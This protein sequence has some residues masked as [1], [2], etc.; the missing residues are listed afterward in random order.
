MHIYQL[1]DVDFRSFGVP[2]ILCS[3]VEISCDIIVI[4][5]YL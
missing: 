2:Y 3:N 4:M 1:A 5:I